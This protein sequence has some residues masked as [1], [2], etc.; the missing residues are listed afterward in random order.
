MIDGMKKEA[1]DAIRR[2]GKT[3]HMLRAEMARP[4]AA[5]L[6]GFSDPREIRAKFLADT[7]TDDGYLSSYIA[8]RLVEGKR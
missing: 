3:W 2:A 8:Q 7:V 6:P 4:V 5:H 1:R